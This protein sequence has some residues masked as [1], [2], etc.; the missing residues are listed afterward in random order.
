MP[1]RQTRRAPAMDLLDFD[2]AV[3]VT[4]PPEPGEDFAFVTT[5]TDAAFLVLAHLSGTRAASILLRSVG[6]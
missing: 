1:L 4:C 6:V 5:E 3:Q 2:L